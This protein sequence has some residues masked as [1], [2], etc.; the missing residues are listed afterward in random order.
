MAGWWVLLP[1][2]SFL[3]ATTGKAQ[4]TAYDSFRPGAEWLD[5]DGVPIRAHSAGLLPGLLRGEF[6]W[7][8]ADNYTSGDGTNTWINVYRSSDLLNWQSLG[9]AYTHPGP[10]P[11]AN[12]PAG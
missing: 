4:P 11:C 9:H 5:T 3:S 7:Y 8:G 2:L 1:A 10:F 12:A 6:Y